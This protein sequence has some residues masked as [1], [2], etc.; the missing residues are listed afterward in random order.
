VTSV[1]EQ[2]ARSAILPSLNPSSGVPLYLQVERSLHARIES[3]EWAPGE[4]I[5]PEDVISA[6]YGVSRITIRQALARLV[7]RGLLVRERGRG[8]FVRDTKLTAGARGVTSFTQELTARGVAAGSVVLGQKVITAA[9]AGVAEALQTEDGDRV[10]QLRRLRT[11]DGR[12]VGVQTSTLPLARFPGLSE[13][14]FADRSL[15]AV[16]RE[17]Y[18]TV[19]AEAIETMSVIGVPGAEAEVLGVRRG[20]PAFQ[21]ER[22]TLDARG[23]FEHVHSIMRG[24][25][26]QIRVVLREP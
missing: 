1:D 10:L 6:S 16:L 7:D 15:Y 24:D 13:I 26:Y 3:G 9:A 17:L 2:P 14:D 12:P 21:I 19:A 23:R 18:G 25:R 4:Q 8:T 20:A 11:G 22:V 5:P